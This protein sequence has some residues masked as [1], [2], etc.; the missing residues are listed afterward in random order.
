M[1]C[2]DGQ[3]R[4][5][6]PVLCQYIGDYPEQT[7]LSC[8]LSGNCPRCLIPPY[9][10]EV[11]EVPN[12]V[13]TPSQKNKKEP[14]VKKRKRNE[15][16]DGSTT[17]EVKRT[18]AG[19][20]D[21]LQKYPLRTQTH[22]EET[23]A[24]YQQSKDEAIL[25]NVGLKPDRPFTDI[26]DH[27]D[28]HSIIAPDILHQVAKMLFDNLYTDWI[29][30]FIAIT[31]GSSVVAVQ[32]EIDAR[33]SQL[34]PYPGLKSFGKGISVTQRWTGNEYKAMA[35]VLLPVVADL[36]SDK[37]VKLVSAYMH[38]IHLSSYTSHTEQT[39]TYLRNAV[40]EY[41]RLRSSSASPLV[42]LD[43]L[44]EGW[45][46]PKQ[47][48]LQHYA[49]WVPQMGP[50]PYCSTDRSEAL[51][52]LHKDSYRRSNK[53]PGDFHRFILNMESYKTVLQWYES[54]LP[55]SDVYPPI[56]TSAS[57]A[58]DVD[59]SDDDDAASRND[60]RDSDDE[61]SEDEECMTTVLQ[62]PAVIGTRIRL[63]GERWK[64]LKYVDDVER[65][66]ELQNLTIE[67]K[68][69][70]RWIRSD[71]T[72]TSQRR[73]EGWQNE[74]IV[75][76]SGHACCEL[77]YPQVYDTNVLITEFLRSTEKWSHGQHKG[78][79][80]YDTVL[81]RWKEEEGDHSMSNRRV[82]RLLLLFSTVCNITR[83]TIEM[84]YVEWMIPAS[85][86]DKKTE[87]FK[88][89][90]SG[91]CGVI[92]VDSIERGVHLV[93]VFD[94]FNT[95]MAATMRPSLETYRDF[96]VNNW[97]DG[98]IYNTI[99]SHNEKYSGDTYLN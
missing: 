65:A 72:Q 91:D 51:H 42:E 90:R 13:V 48:W 58:D 17:R 44:A 19:S 76:I 59:G 97:L 62:S 92:G 25:K 27:S 4:Q 34:P 56:H 39:I 53:N 47:H 93:P 11:V 67:T 86:W 3:R 22:H 32:Q 43:I 94:G 50:L 49:D 68:K 28:I 41:T 88:V 6:H 60:P 69:C 2:P 30:P 54:T 77:Q 5:C 61:T 95:P 74:E 82:G 52:K 12:D 87:M 16:Q 1:L 75:Q 70:I 7:L 64:G 66:L 29:V 8:I 46:A 85:T 23:R 21:P 14:H 55:D 24:R 71:R 84:A 79:P 78:H 9:A 80:R 57:A 99:Y 36:L 31:R 37:M 38:I 10:R 35:R 73:L 81:I 18:K 40:D 98:H 96:W 33:F 45:W 89:K 26:F 15:K 63:I 20:G 83:R